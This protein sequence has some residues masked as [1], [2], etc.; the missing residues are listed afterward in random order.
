LAQEDDDGKEYAIYYLSQKLQDTETKYTLTEK[1]CLA[2]VWAT[3][4]LRHYCLANSTKVISQID[5]LKY[6]HQT[7]SLIGL[8]SR[9]LILLTELDL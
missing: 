3:H 1:T 9:W 7:P 2:L 4:K 8:L 5:P 6:L